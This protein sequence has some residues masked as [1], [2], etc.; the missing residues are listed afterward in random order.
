MTYRAFACFAFLAGMTGCPSDDAVAGE[1]GSAT[2]PADTDPGNTEPGETEPAD[3]EPVDTD[4]ADTDPADTDPSDTDP[5][6]TETGGPMACEHD[7]VDDCCCFSD[8]GQFYV[9]VTCTTEM[10]CDSVQLHCPGMS[11][12]C[13][14]AEATLVDP[15]TLDCALQAIADGSIGQISYS[16]T[17]ADIPGFAWESQTLH[18]RGDGTAFSFRSS[19]VDSPYPHEGV[20]HVELSPAAVGCNDLADDLDRLQC[21]L[22]ATGPSLDTCLPSGA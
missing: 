18:L 7:V 12:D 14:P 17:G 3:T 1:S 8:N 9:E 10:L 2:E 21:L 4:P 15:A 16:F 20:Q 6:D 22:D 19:G 5:V 11:A 13:S